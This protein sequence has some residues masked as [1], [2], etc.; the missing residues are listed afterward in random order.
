MLSEVTDGNSRAQ[1]LRVM[2][3][4]DAEAVRKKVNALWEANYRDDG[5]VTSI[6]ANS[7][8]LRD[9]ISY[10]TDTIKNLAEKYYASVYSGDVNS[11]E[12]NDAFREWINGNTKNMLKDMTSDLKFNDATV[13]TLVSTICFQAK[14]EN[15]FSEENT[16][17]DIF[18]TKEGSEIKCDFL[19]EKKMQVYSV[20]GDNYVAVKLHLVNSGGMWI[21]LPNKDSSVDDILKGDALEAIL[22]GKNAGYIRANVSIPKFDI[23]SKLDLV[24]LLA[25]LGITDVF[26]DET[27]DFSPLTDMELYISRAEQGVRVMIDEEGC[28]AAAYTVMMMDG[29]GTM[30]PEEALDFVADRPFMFAITG[31]DGSVL[32]TGIINNPAE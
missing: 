11:G 23:S 32:F 10:N 12:Y 25:E 14:W 29:T 9:G 4:E 21:V 30:P 18:T 20:S 13:A 16:K 15:E 19:N 1:V 5:A 2:G 26:D 27:S 3:Q 8:W 31:T 22:T 24:E 6:L 28:A 17:E 7:L